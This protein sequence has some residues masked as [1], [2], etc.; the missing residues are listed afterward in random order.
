METQKV[1]SLFVGT[2][3]V[4]QRDGLLRK[5]AETANLNFEQFTGEG[6]IHAA[7]GIRTNSN[8]SL[9]AAAL[10]CRPGEARA[11]LGVAT[12]ATTCQALCLWH[13]SGSTVRVG[14]CACAGYAALRPRSTACLGRLHVTRKSWGARRPTFL[15][16]KAV[17]NQLTEPIS[18]RAPGR[19]GAAAVPHGRHD[20]MAA[21]DP[22][23]ANAHM[24]TEYQLSALL[25]KVA[26]TPACCA[27]FSK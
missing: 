17:A 12:H 7:R 9:R 15:T 25:D 22:L 1:T 6:R 8:L 26:T 20:G 11:R 24:K 21:P 23:K 5:L 18:R 27:I 10:W 16:R 14:V 19:H 2:G 3:P 13:R 4:C